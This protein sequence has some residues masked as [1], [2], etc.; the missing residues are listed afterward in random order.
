MIVRSCLA[1]L[2]VLA[3]CLLVETAVLPGTCNA[4][5]WSPKSSE[6][7][8]KVEIATLRCSL[9]CQIVVVPE[10][11]ERLCL[12][13]CLVHS[14]NESLSLPDCHQH[15]L[16]LNASPLCTSGCNISAA[17]IR[18]RAELNTTTEDELPTNSDLVTSGG[19]AM[20]CSSKDG[21]ELLNE[22]RAFISGQETCIVETCTNGSLDHSS[23]SC[24]AVQRKCCVSGEVSNLIAE[25]CGFCGG[26]P[27][28][29]TS[30]PRYTFN[31]NTLVI[32]LPPALS[33]FMTAAQSVL[34]RV[35][36]ETTV[37]L[38][39]LLK[40]SATTVSVDVNPSACTKL[41]IDYAAVNLRAVSNFSAPIT[42]TVV[43]SQVENLTVS[44][45]E[46]PSLLQ[47]T[48]L[49]LSWTPPRV[50]PHMVSGYR[51]SFE[52]TA[53]SPTFCQ[54]RSNYTKILKSDDLSLLLS[55]NNTDVELLPLYDCNYTLNVATL[56]GGASLSKDVQIEYRNED[57]KPINVTCTAKYRPETVTYDISVDWTIDALAAAAVSKYIVQMLFN[58]ER[59]FS[60]NRTEVKEQQTV[61][62]TGIQIS[63]TVG[64]Y[65][66]SLARKQ[67]KFRDVLV[68][69]SDSTNLCLQARSRNQYAT[70][71]WSTPLSIPSLSV[72]L[73]PAPSM[74]TPPPPQLPLYGS[75]LIG[76][77]VVVILAAVAVPLLILWL[78]LRN[79]A[80][81]YGD[82]YFSTVPHKNSSIKNTFGQHRSSISS[83]CSQ[84]LHINILPTPPLVTDDWEIPYD[85]LQV[86]YSQ[87]LG[88]GA[89]GEV[90]KG[91]VRSQAMKSGVKRLPK[92]SLNC[93]VAVKKLKDNAAF[94]EKLSFLK[95]IDMMKRVTNSENEYS[96][97]VVNMVGCVTAR[98]PFLLVL[99]YVRHGDLLK[100]LRAMKA[101]L[102]NTQ[103]ASPYLEPQGAYS[104]LSPKDIYEDLE[105][106]EDK[107]LL[108]F[109]RQIAA[110]MEYLSSLDIIHRDLACRNILVGDNKNLKISD[111]GMSR[112]LPNEEA[113]VLTSQGQLP[114]RWMALETLFQR[115]FNTSSDV[116]SYGVVLWEI[117]TMGDLPYPVYTNT[118]VVQQLRRG[119]RMPKPHKCSPEVYEVMLHC[120]C[121]NG[122]D[123]PSFSELRQRFD[124]FL[125]L[126]V[127]EHHPYIEIPDQPYQ[128]DRLAPE[129]GQVGRN[130]FLDEGDSP[131]NLEQLGGVNEG[132]VQK[133]NNTRGIVLSRSMELLS[134]PPTHHHSHTSLDE[135]TARYTRSPSSNLLTPDLSIEGDLMQQLDRR[136]SFISVSRLQAK[137]SEAKRNET[138][139]ETVLEFS[140]SPSND[141][142]DI[143]LLAASKL[144][145]RSQSNRENEH[146]I[147]IPQE[148]NKR[149]LKE[150]LLSKHMQ[151]GEDEYD[152]ENQGSEKRFSR[153]ESLLERKKRDYFKFTLIPTCGVQFNE[154]SDSAH[155]K[156]EVLI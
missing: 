90:F 66:T 95:E 130:S 155:G 140:P 63:E 100:Y 124:H 10:D 138:K 108:E 132:E 92:F 116:W 110:G 86:F 139:Q 156:N 17:F 42:F 51:V 78:C 69:L 111:F 145:E 46:D 123:R 84:I 120:W 34:L 68:L 24:S 107:D 47:H 6:A 141:D 60:F 26:L 146:N 97:F 2:I 20:V 128:F 15:C 44:F 50:R 59:S 79:R 45:S 154:S 149:P 94:S 19:E 56:P 114:L 106:L 73:T 148:E 87:P 72:S 39:P 115:E 122:G 58:N 31:N 93:T 151:E 85:D 119:H 142:V 143:D 135:N 35:R 11:S 136:L 38:L 21:R 153:R 33:S 13:G 67:F 9:G 126:H 131:L 74:T 127:Q 53:D 28:H 49:Q 112:H 81:K 83:N 40:P 96:C 121:E 7:E 3:A 91:L 118:E 75:V 14:L 80:V 104:T 65:A 25:C 22:E 37:M 27:V 129:T 113:Y 99:E 147:E 8:E 70:S 48:I 144:E 43:P 4:A 52:P 57:K 150:N 62:I 30:P 102:R 89:F 88:K 18:T 117:S 103:I 137:L 133:R 152:E 32:S 134:P 76:V 82:R 23:L 55:A 29:P 105:L 101:K 12:E 61:T 1:V 41:V 54:Q 71:S 77:S 36:G 16:D 64:Y 125:S 5:T 109:S 98:E